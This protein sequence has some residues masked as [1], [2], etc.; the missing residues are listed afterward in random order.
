MDMIM[1]PSTIEVETIRLAFFLACAAIVWIGYQKRL[2]DRKASF[3]TGILG[4]YF[5]FLFPL[6]WFSSLLLLYLATSFATKQKSRW[7]QIFHKK[8][9]KIKNIASNLAP[10]VL[11]SALY[12][13]DH[14]PYF[15][16]AF[17]CSAACACSDTVASEIGQLSGK[18]PRLITTWEEVKT[19]VDGGIS[20]LGTSAAALGSL[21][22]AAP[23]IF[24]SP[25]A[26][27]IKFFVIASVI[28]FL[29]CNID[30]YLGARFQLRGK[31]SNEGTNLAA[32]GISAVLGLL[33]W[34]LVF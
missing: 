30:S 4:F 8:G 28:G 27:A 1:V 19:G 25:Q 23:A 2:T 16:L 26:F 20:G 10:S 5:I 34:F 21:V 7:K 11:F 6:Y 3:F 12:L 18:K 14:Q 13:I 22:T 15:Y 9:R 32:T 24:M 33:V 17:L 31:L 29:G